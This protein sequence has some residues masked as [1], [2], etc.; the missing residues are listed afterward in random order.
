MVGNL[1][2]GVPGVEKCRGPGAN[3]AVDWKGGGA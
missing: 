3:F 1:F 2:K